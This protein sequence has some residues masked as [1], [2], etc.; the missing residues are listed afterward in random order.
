MHHPSADGQTYYL[1]ERL[2]DQIRPHLSPAVYETAVEHGK[3][4]ELK[5]VCARILARG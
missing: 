1:A 2:V 5:E 3:A 4:M